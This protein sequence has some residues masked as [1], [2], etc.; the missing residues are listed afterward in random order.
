MIQAT[1]ELNLGK[2]EDFFSESLRLHDQWALRLAESYYFKPA[3]RNYWDGCSTGGR[4]GL[5]LASKDGRTS[6]GS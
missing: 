6:M 2:I 3:A 1:H 4:Q 5:V